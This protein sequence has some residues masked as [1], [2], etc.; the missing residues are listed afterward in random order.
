M[1]S[2]KK[3]M[4]MIS[5]LIEEIEN[6][7]TYKVNVLD[8]SKQLDLSP[9][10]FQRL[11]KSI[12]GD[13]IGSYIR[14]RRLS[15]AS[16]LLSTTSRTIIDIAFEVGFNSH[17]SFTRSF[18]AFFNYSPKQY[19]KVKPKVLT[20]QKPVLSQELLTHLIDGMDLKPHIVD[21]PKQ[22]IVGLETSVPSPFTTLDP[23]CESVGE[24]WFKLFDRENEI[25]GADNSKL[26][27]LTISPSGFYTEDLL[28]YIAGI[29]VSKIYIIPHGMT[30]FIIPKQKVAVFDVVTNVDDEIA[31]KTVDFIYGYWLYNSGYERGSGTD[32][33]LFEDIIDRY[34]G[35]FK[36]KYVIP[37]K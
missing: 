12:V 16:E 10:H 25:L 2:I 9:W 24:T 26:C 36:T 37:L 3:H 15:R 29:P 21:L 35:N 7:L 33:E 6:N 14:G 32:Y 27:A 17:E 11:F 31:K 8:L 30:S 1:T 19:R 22:Y 34:T 23:I 18:K 5:Q 28:R 13:S 4:E 20:N